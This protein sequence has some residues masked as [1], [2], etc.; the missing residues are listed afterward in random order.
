MKNKE[1]TVLHARSNDLIS[2][3]GRKTEF[4]EIIK[5]EFNLGGKIF[6]AEISVAKCSVIVQ[7]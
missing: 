6:E 5:E 7:V 1:N 4:P 3:K 2:V